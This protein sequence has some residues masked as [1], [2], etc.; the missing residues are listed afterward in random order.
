MF[1]L[2]GWRLK[3]HIQTNEW[4]IAQINYWMKKTVRNRKVP[5]EKAYIVPRQRKHSM[6]A[7][8]LLAVPSSGSQVFWVCWLRGWE[9]RDGGSDIPILKKHS[10]GMQE[11]ITLLDCSELLAGARIKLTNISWKGG[12]V[13][14][15]VKRVLWKPCHFERVKEHGV[16]HKWDTVLFSLKELWWSVWDRRVESLVTS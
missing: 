13:Q 12:W 7:E 8:M 5:L 15:L 14:C 4:E 10:T 16:R 1:K 6:T 11:G 3:I 2:Y 9:A